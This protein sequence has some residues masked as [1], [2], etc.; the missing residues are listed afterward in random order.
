[1]PPST[2]FV[3]I[4]PTQ[5]N[6]TIHSLGAL[7]SSNS[8][9]IM[10]GCVAATS[11]ILLIVAA[12]MLWKR[13]RASKIKRKPSTVRWN[14]H[15]YEE[16]QNAGA[17]EDFTEQPSE[18]YTPLQIEHYEQ[19]YLSLV[20]HDHVTVKPQVDS[21]TTIDGY[22]ALQQHQSEYPYLDLTNQ[23]KVTK[24]ITLQEKRAKITR[25]NSSVDEPGN[26]VDNNNN[27][28]EKQQSKSQYEDNESVINETKPSYDYNQMKVNE[29]KTITPYATVQCDDLTDS[30]PIVQFVAPK[31]LTD[32]K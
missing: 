3:N 32:E 29:E 19:P 21:T 23:P 11:A 10:Y 1:M 18:N 6:C 22:T 5:S 20:T 12:G 7:S 26:K 31:Y 4:L 14:T 30:L 16:V 28:D 9:L 15:V 24:E 8:K 25:D 27:H 17:R 13:R 2:D